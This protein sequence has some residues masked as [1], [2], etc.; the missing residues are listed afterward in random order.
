LLAQRKL[1]GQCFIK[2]HA[3]LRIGRAAVV[4]H[5]G[6]G[7]SGQLFGQGHGS[8]KRLAVVDH[9]VGQAHGQRLIGA[10]GPAR[11]DQIQR[12]R[13][14]D[15]AGQAHRTAV[16][17]RHTKSAAKHAQHGRAFDHT[18]VAPQRQL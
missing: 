14:A 10:H 17:Q 7:Q 6:L 11:E 16:D 15:Q 1:M 18:Q 4:A 9:T 2:T 3:E 8:L 12:T 13:Q 5:A